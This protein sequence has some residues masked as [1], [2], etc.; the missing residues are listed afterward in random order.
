MAYRIELHP[1]AEVE[2]WEA[3]DWYDAQKENLGKSFARAI[4]NAVV[5]IQ[6]NP[7]RFPF[8]HANKRKVVISG[9]PYIVVF[10]VREEFVLI[11]TIFHTSRDPE[12]WELR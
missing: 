3:I 10:E 11:L 6:D 12:N 2:L 7:K 8:A 4:Q 5:T 1:M 9:F